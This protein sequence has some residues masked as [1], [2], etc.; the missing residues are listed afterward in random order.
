MINRSSTIRGVMGTVRHGHINLGSPGGPVKAF[1]FLKPANINGARLTGGLTRCLF[2]STSTLIH[3][4]VDRC[5]R[6]FT[7]SH[8][9]N[10]PPKCMNCRRNNR[11]ARGI[12]HG[13]C[14][15]ILLS[16]VRGTRPSIFG[17]LLR[18][19]SRNH[20]A[21][22]LNEQVSFG[23]AVLVVASGV[24]AHRLGSFNHNINFDSRTTNRP[25]GS[26]SHDIVRGTLG[27]TFTP[28]FLGHISSVVVFSRLSGRTVRGVVSVRLRNLCGH[29]T[30][31]NCSLRLASTTGSFITAGN[32]SVRFNTH[33]LG[34]T[35]RGCLRSRVTRVVVQTSIKRNSAVII[36]FS[37]SGRRVIAGVGGDRS[38]TRT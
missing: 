29:I 7:I 30:N 32:C 24:N 34:H 25:S 26:F 22:D 12:H 10:T 31:L 38:T 11:L 18:I 14:S 9:V 3:V 28:R 8:L 13:P 2:S 17:L 35:V 1:V 36:S 5:L 15:I 20:L 23:G 4:S 6:G 37:G 19:L 33:P 27:G 21:S 16:R